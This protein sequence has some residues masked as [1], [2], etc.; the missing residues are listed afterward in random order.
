MRIA[1]FTGFNLPPLQF[2][3]TAIRKTICLIR[4]LV[5]PINGTAGSFHINQKTNEIIRAQS[6]IDNAVATIMPLNAI[7]Y[8]SFEESYFIQ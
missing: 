4:D 8:K 7:T 1:N 3:G 6:G 5:L 2:S